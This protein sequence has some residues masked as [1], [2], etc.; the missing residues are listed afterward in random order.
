ML[1]YLTWPFG[2]PIPSWASLELAGAAA[3]HHFQLCPWPILNLKAWLVEGAVGAAVAAE[4]AAG[5]EPV[6]AAG[7]PLLSPKVAAAV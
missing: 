1:Y 4:A 2:C 3:A 6:A 5:L 7:K